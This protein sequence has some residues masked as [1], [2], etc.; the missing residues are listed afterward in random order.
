MTVSTT[1]SSVTYIG[2]GST[3]SFTFS[4]IGVSSTDLEVIYTDA[5]GVESILN[6]TQYTLVVNSPSVGQLW[7][8]GGTVT[9][10]ITGTAIQNPSQI[11]INRIV[12][13]TQTVSMANQGAFYPQAVEQGLDLI[14]LQLQ[15]INT[16]QTYSLKTPITDAS[17]PQLLP[18]AAERA[19]GFLAFDSTGEPIVLPGAG[20]NGGVVSVAMTVP[21]ALLTVSGSPVTTSGTLALSLPTQNAATVLAGPVTGNAPAAPSFRS[22][23]AGD[24]PNATV[25]TKGAVI[26]DGNTIV[27]STSTI[28]VAPATPRIVTV[29]GT[30]TSTLTTADEYKGISLYQSGA[31]A[32]TVQLP[33]SGSPYPVFDASGNSATFPIT[34]KPPA[35]LLINGAST[36]TMNTNFGNKSFFNDTTQI[37]VK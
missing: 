22:L 26:P 37:L 7:G 13:Y 17:P 32:T 5:N 19:N 23:V 20:V 15:Q 36:Y 1:P 33:T 30:F 28:S 18:T 34:V 27:I 2:N 16:E 21:S 6:P 8:I 3:T 11:T 10:P 14:E 25:S 4:F 9:Y 24:L 31:A 12:P 29:T 35:G